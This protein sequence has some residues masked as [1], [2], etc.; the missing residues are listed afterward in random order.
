MKS[1]FRQKSIARKHPKRQL[2]YLIL[3]YQKQYLPKKI[4]L[5]FRRRPSSSVRPSIRP[6]PSPAPAI[7]APLFVMG[8]TNILPTRYPS[9]PEGLDKTR[10]AGFFL[11]YYSHHAQV[12]L[13]KKSRLMKKTI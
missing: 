2:P 8:Q 13:N 9:P 7:P 5:S 1:I 3:S 11:V 4:C 10:A 6:S 12:D